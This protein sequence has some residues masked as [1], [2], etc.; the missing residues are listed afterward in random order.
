MHRVPWQINAVVRRQGGRPF[1]PSWAAFLMGIRN[2]LFGPVYLRAL[3]RGGG[4]CI[5]YK[6]RETL[7]VVADDSI[8]VR[9]HCSA[10]T[11]CATAVIAIAASI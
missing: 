8:R 10:L 1:S 11:A 6:R 5:Q 9:C 4:V 7:V 2:A 3:A